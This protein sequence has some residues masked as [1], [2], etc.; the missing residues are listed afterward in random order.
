MLK[1]IGE[2]TPDSPAQLAGLA[3]GGPKIAFDTTIST[4]GTGVKPR[5]TS[6]AADLGTG[7]DVIDVDKV[8]SQPGKKGGYER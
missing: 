1:V 2:E 8:F 5:P 7:G 4:F 6:Y 3:A